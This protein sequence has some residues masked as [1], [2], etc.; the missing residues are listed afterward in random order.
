MSVLE[1]PTSRPTPRRR[2]LDV[3]ARQPLAVAG[4]AVIA[5]FVIVAILARQFAPDGASSQVGHPFAAPSPAHLLGLDDVGADVVSQ[6]ILGA[7]VSLLIGVLAA[8]VAVSIG[9]SIGAIS[10]YFGGIVDTLLVAAT[11]YFLVIPILPLA[12]VVAALWGANLTNEVLIISLLSWMST[13][14]L[15][16]AQVVSLRERAFVART[17]SLGASNLRI[18]GRHILPAVTPLVAASVVISVGNA[19][20][21]EAAL[22]FLGLTDPSRPSWGKMIADGFNRGAIQAGAWW[23]IVT[24]GLAIGLVVLSASLVGRAVEDT[25]NPRL[26]ISHVGVRVFR[27][28]RAQDELTS[29]EAP[30][31]H[32]RRRRRGS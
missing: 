31:V 32:R 1:L 10:G 20:F 5:G 4:V 27:I 12:I 26:A 24:P 6:L 19:I 23:A 30:V 28:E 9:V 2:A 3:V 21:F 18:L 29:S 17:R 11:D 16:R 7:R 14:R 15:I 22:A 13:A 8:A 25:A